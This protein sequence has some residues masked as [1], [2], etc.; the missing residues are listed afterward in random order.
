MTNRRVMDRLR[1]GR[2]N[3]G[4][5]AGWKGLENKMA[6]TVGRIWGEGVGA[7]RDAI[8]GEARRLS[9]WQPLSATTCCDG[10]PFALMRGH[11]REA[12]CHISTAA[13]ALPNS[14]VKKSSSNG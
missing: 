14:A 2:R 7:R 13:S 8:A 10:S 4:G 3:G 11:L 1:E 9:P 5:E 6:D 12:R